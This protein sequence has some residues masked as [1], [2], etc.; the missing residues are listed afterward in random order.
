MED[1]EGLEG[2]EGSLEV[3]VEGSAV[4]VWAALHPDWVEGSPAG[5]WVDYSPPG[6]EAAAVCLQVNADA[7]LVLA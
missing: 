1:L 5:F 6:S 2:L 7:Y 3:F 4:V